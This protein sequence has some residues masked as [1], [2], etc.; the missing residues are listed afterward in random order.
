VYKWAKGS[1][2]PTYTA[3]EISGLT[4]FIE[5]NFHISGDITIAPRIYQI[6]QGTNENS[7]KYYLRYKE[8]NDEGEWITDTNHPIDLSKYNE[9]YDWIG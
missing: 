5:E 4:S 6:V 1:V 9:I 7:N 3:T 2:K 8:N